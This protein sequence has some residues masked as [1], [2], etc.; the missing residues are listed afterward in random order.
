MYVYLMQIMLTKL[1]LFADLL[2]IV[3]K[4]VVYGIL[5][6]QYYFRGTIVYISPYRVLSM[7]SLL[8]L[9]LNLTNHA[10]GQNPAIKAI[11]TNKG[12]QYGKK[13]LFP[14]LSWVKIPNQRNCISTATLFMCP[15]GSHIGA[16][17]MQEKIGSVIIPDVRGGVDIGIGTV[18]YV[19]DRYMLWLLFMKLK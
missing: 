4:K 10:F 6:K 2:D 11:L 13:M 7:L 19:L 8:I 12:L 3:E 9:L 5:W 15:P 17:W 18:H 16:D 14:Q 1:S